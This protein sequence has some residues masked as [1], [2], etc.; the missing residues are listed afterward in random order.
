MRSHNEDQEDYLCGAEDFAPDGAEHD[1]AGVG[2]VVDVRV[3]EF[4]LPN[5]EAGV[6][7]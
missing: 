7:G 4:E 2:H 3:A 1:V 6:G 5:H